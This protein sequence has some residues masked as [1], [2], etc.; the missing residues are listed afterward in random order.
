MSVG[1]T[2]SVHETSEGDAAQ[3]SSKN[4]DAAE[5]AYKAFTVGAL[6]RVAVDDPPDALVGGLIRNDA[7]HEEPDSPLHLG[8]Q[9]V[10]STPMTLS[11]SQWPNPLLSTASGGRSEMGTRPGIGKRDVLLPP[12]LR[13][14]LCPRGWH[15]APGSWIPWHGAGVPRGSRGKRRA[16][17][18]FP[19]HS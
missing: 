15:F 9:V 5:Q 17:D 2:S 16:D 1:C 3:S 6:D 8:V 12:R 14:R 7:G 4:D 11:A 10:H 13:R 18:M 19:F